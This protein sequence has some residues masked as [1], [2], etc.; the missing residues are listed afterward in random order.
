MQG[1]KLSKILQ[2]K[3]HDIVLLKQR[4]KLWWIRPRQDSNLQS[5]D[6]K[7]G[8]LSIRPRGHLMSGKSNDREEYRYFNLVWNRIYW[9]YWELWQPPMIFQ[10]SANVIFGLIK[11]Y[12]AKFQKRNWTTWLFLKMTNCWLYLLLRYRSERP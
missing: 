12:T 6:P 9:E 5:P 11:W 3:W 7:S 2:V 1:G 4:L 8:A 10:M